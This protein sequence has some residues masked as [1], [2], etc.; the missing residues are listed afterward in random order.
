M[1]NILPCT[2]CKFLIRPDRPNPYCSARDSELTHVIYNPLTQ[3][4]VTH[5]EWRP[6]I[7][8]ER[9]TGK[10]GPGRTLYQDKW[11]VRFYNRYVRR[12]PYAR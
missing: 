7:T 8:D 12:D 4:Y 1:S 2:G 3:R 5:H 11:Y 10:C 6:F 9:S